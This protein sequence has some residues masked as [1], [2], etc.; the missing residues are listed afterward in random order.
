[1]NNSEEFF[2]QTVSAKDHHMLCVCNVTLRRVTRYLRSLALM[3]LRCFHLSGYSPEFIFIVMDDSRKKKYIWYEGRRQS[4]LAIIKFSSVAG[5]H[6][7][8]FQAR[9]TS[10]YS[11]TITWYQW[12]RRYLVFC[13]AQSII[14]IGLLPCFSLL[15][16]HAF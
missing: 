6:I 7:S 5:A 16:I 9:M 4:L 13:E 10:F 15:F 1:M 8:L 12:F 3:T 14:Y 2:E 11:A